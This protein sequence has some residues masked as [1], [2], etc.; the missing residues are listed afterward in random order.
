ML[1]TIEEAYF[2]LYKLWTTKNYKEF[3]ESDNH[4]NCLVDWITKA[5]YIYN[6]C[7]ELRYIV[8]DD[9]IDFACVMNNI[10]QSFLLNIKNKGKNKEIFNREIA[11]ARDKYEVI[12]QKLVHILRVYSIGGN[13][14]NDFLDLLMRYGG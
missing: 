12:R 4:Y 6:E 1:Q 9:F 2:I 7:R 5:D 3:T 8:S 14:N 10:F 11:N 13:D